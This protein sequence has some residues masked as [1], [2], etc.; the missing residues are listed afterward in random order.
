MNEIFKGMDNASELINENF[1]NGSIV[2]TG[3]NENGTFM[4][5]GNGWMVC[6]MEATFSRDV[7]EVK[8][9]YP[10]P[11]IGRPTVFKS[12]YADQF[13]AIQDEALLGIGTTLTNYRI[14]KHT[15]MPAYRGT[16][17]LTLNVIAIGRWK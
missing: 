7:S 8:G 9:E 5:L 2:E 4:K 3:E 15:S 17:E 16:G 13:A 1:K 10:I 12:A 11:F 6:Q 14:M